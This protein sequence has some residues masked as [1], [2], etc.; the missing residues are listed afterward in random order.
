MGE[1]FQ[2]FINKVES[3]GY[4]NSVFGLPEQF[5]S[6]RESEGSLRNVWNDRTDY[7]CASF[8]SETQREDCAQS[9][10]SFQQKETTPSRNRSL[11]EQA[12]VL[13]FQYSI[14]AEWEVAKQKGRIH[15]Q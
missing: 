11:Q 7:H 14:N 15:F 4:F 13:D 9:I 2:D 1:N 3:D 12:A 10:Q 8:P 5:H 6:H